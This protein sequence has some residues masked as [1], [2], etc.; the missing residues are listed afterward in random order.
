M[1]HGEEKRTKAK[2]MPLPGIGFSLFIVLMAILASIVVGYTQLVPSAA[3]PPTK[4]KLE[5]DPHRMY[6][7]QCDVKVDEMVEYAARQIKTHNGSMRPYLKFVNNTR[8]LLSDPNS[9]DGYLVRGALVTLMN[10]ARD[11]LNTWV[12]SRDMNTYFHEICPLYET[13]ILQNRA[14][15]MWLEWFK[16][17]NI[18]FETVIKSWLSV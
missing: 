9:A 11:M 14:Y 16:H 18:E 2:P 3:V 5:D 12:M 7:D 15:V 13:R 8:E 1:E 17:V 6:P 10:T 4:L